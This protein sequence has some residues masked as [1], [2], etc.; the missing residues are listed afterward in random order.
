MDE[1]SKEVFVVLFA[2]LILGISISY[3]KGP[4]DYLIGI[5]SCAIVIL[6]NV[7]VK[8]ITAHHFESDIVT[9]PWSIQRF[10]FQTRAKFKKPFP[11][12]WLPL[13]LS[14]LSSA[15]FWWFAVLQFDAKPRVE[16]M[17]RRHRSR[18]RK[19]HMTE[20]HIG[21]IAF[22]GLAANAVLA[23]ISV[24]FGLTFLAKISIV[25]ALWAL[26]PI[27]NLDGTKILF[28]HKGIWIFSAI[29][30]VVLFVFIYQ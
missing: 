20:E 3:G 23:L 8:N 21:L 18:H 22:S 15:A 29:V 13:V 1:K 17:V 2:A 11:M 5:V 24:I 7:V 25:Y 12:I 10:G 9:K 6:V 27:S 14:M 19:T 16:R 28:S 26:V 4:L 30:S